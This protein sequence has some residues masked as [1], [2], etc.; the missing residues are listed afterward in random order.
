M[1]PVAFERTTPAGKRPQAYA[2]DLAIAG[3]GIKYILHIPN[4]Y[5]CNII[6]DRS[7]I[8]VNLTFRGPCIVIYSY[9]K[10][11]EMH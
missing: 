4:G 11:N 5:I 10:T 9:N 2:L 1:P 8:I 7:V 6:W 3:T